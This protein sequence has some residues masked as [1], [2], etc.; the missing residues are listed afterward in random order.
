MVAQQAFLAWAIT[1]PCNHGN[2]TNSGHTNSEIPTIFS[3]VFFSRGRFDNGRYSS[4]YQL[5][6]IRE[7]HSMYTVYTVYRAERDP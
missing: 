7:D 6:A 3:V 1:G 2:S 4:S 5:V